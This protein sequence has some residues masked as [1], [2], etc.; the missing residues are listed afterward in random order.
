MRGDR[1]GEGGSEAMNEPCAVMGIDDGGGMNTGG[2][3]ERGVRSWVGWLV[4][5]ARVWL[6]V[7]ILL[8]L[9]RPSNDDAA[10]ASV[11]EKGRERDVYLHPPS[12]LYGPSPPEL[13]GKT[14]GDGGGIAGPG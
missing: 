8:Y 13:V 1:R 14:D 4:G 7:F 9:A 10:S 3:R 5:L 12:P 6:C 11:G 2:E